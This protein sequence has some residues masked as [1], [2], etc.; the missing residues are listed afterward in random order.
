MD[1]NKVR[2]IRANQIERKQVGDAARAQVDGFFNSNAKAIKQVFGERPQELVRFY[3]HP[4]PDPELTHKLGRPVFN[5]RA[6]CLIHVPDGKDYTSTPATPELAQLYPD[7]WG[8]FVEQVNHRSHSLKVLPRMT[9][10]AERMFHEIGVHSVDDLAE[11]TD[12]PAD[13]APFQG[14]AVK[15]LE[16]LSAAIDEGELPAPTKMTATVIPL[17]MKETSDEEVD[18]ILRGKTLGTQKPRV[19]AVDGQFKESA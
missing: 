7:A 17:G 8:R 12:L 16:L 11:R 14:W 9:P 15:W 13:L 3:Y 6:Y 2:E 18:A 1:A 4:Q 19:R 5:D 10:S